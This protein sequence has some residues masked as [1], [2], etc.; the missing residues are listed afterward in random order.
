VITRI[1]APELPPELAAALPFDRYRA[2]IGGRLMHLVDHGE[3]PPVL[4]VHGNPTWSFLWRKVIRRLAGVRA[5]APDLFGFGLS[6]KPGGRFHTVDAHVGALCELVDALGGD[7][8]VVVGQDWGGPLACGVA[9]HLDRQ[10]RLHGLVLAN[11]AV[12]PA[13]RPVRATSFHALSHAPLVSE[14]LFFGLRFP[15]PVLGQV[16]RRSSSIGSFERAAYGFPFRRLRDRAGPLALARMVPN[17]DRHPSLPA[18]DAIGR[19]VEEW[20]G[21]R[22]LVWGLDDPILGRALPRLRQAFGDA[23]VT[24]VRAGHFLQEEVPDEIAAMVQHIVAVQR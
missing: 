3:G 23:P 22:G 20:R 17:R 6:D 11:T 24:E 10:G 15:I 12:L 2:A 14:L 7:G 21:P 5:V 1:P 18:L 4:L 19:W 8:W 13:R 9:R 16:Q